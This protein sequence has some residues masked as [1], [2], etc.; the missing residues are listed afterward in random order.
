MLISALELDML[1][2]SGHTDWP[3]RRP[4]RGTAVDIC[5]YRGKEPSPSAIHAHRSALLRWRETVDILV[6]WNVWNVRKALAAQHNAASGSNCVPEAEV[7]N[8]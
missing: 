2:P 8:F 4:D 3:S 7:S 1:A 5:G 6:S